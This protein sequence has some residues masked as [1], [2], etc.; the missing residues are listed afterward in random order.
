MQQLFAGAKYIGKFK[1]S[2]IGS[3]VEHMFE[4]KDAIYVADCKSGD[5]LKRRD[6]CCDVVAEA[7][8]FYKWKNV[9]APTKPHK[10]IIITKKMPTSRVSINRLKLAEE[11]GLDGIYLWDPEQ[12]NL[13]EFFYG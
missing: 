6:T 8:E 10:F 2:I 11:Y 5:G 12:P 9:T 3:T 13:V 4:Y 1:N 7:L